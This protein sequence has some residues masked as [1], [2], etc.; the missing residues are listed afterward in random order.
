MSLSHLTACFTD[1]HTFSSSVPI[2]ELLILFSS[3]IQTNHFGMIGEVWQR[4]DKYNYLQPPTF[5]RG[6]TNRFISMRQSVFS[7]FEKFSLQLVESM[8]FYLFYDVWV[9]KNIFGAVEKFGRLIWFS[10]K[11]NLTSSFDLD[12]ILKNQFLSLAINSQ[13]VVQS[14]NFWLYFHLW[15]KHTILQPLARVGK[16]SISASNCSLLTFTLR[17]INRL[18]STR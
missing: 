15:P 11:S 7:D 14:M 9:E 5:A 3:L 18:I 17:F 2:N 10:L 4:F 8:K 6:F 12:N 1:N 13:Q 16:N